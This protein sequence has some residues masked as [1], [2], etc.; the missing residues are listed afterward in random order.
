MRR[1]TMTIADKAT[2]IKAALGDGGEEFG[3]EDVLED[4]LERRMRRH[5]LAEL[6]ELANEEEEPEEPGER[7]MRRGL[8]RRMLAELFDEDWDPGERLLRRLVRRHLLAELFDGG[9]IA[10]RMRRRAALR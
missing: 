1:S 9:P 10:R 6:A 8:R 7:I 4:A 2:E 5:L 3:A